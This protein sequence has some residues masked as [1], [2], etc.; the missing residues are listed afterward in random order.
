M[1]RERSNPLSEW[2]RHGDSRQRDALVCAAVSHTAP[3]EN[4]LLLGLFP[5]DGRGVPQGVRLRIS[6]TGATGRLLW[7]IMEMEAK[8]HLILP[9]PPRGSLIC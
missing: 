6:M 1:V 9:A 5:R 8:Q 4:T 2:M 7:R 3:A